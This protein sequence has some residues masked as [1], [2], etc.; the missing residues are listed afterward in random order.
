MSKTFKLFMGI[1]VQTL[2]NDK[3]KGQNILESQMYNSLENLN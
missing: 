1:E 3:E 2:L